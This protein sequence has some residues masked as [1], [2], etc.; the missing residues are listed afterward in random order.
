MKECF[1]EK[2][3]GQVQA[4]V[5]RCERRLKEDG[6]CGELSSCRACGGN[7]SSGT[8]HSFAVPLENRV[9]TFIRGKNSNELRF[10]KGRL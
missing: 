4:M 8:D 1:R 6:S 2:H 9:I 10:S 5:I 7:T 3:F